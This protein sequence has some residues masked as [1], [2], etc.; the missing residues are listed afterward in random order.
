MFQTQQTFLFQTPQF[1]ELPVP[2][3]S[4]SSVSLMA[5]QKVR[6]IL[7]QQISPSIINQSQHSPT[8]NSPVL[9]MPM[10]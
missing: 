6:Y 4:G 8:T 3:I 7:T 1:L 5:A 10:V 9:S 2:A